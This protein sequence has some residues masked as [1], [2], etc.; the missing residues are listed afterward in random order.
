MPN[1]QETKPLRR[2]ASVIM[3]LSFMFMFSLIVLGFLK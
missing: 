3:A 2:V 1:Q